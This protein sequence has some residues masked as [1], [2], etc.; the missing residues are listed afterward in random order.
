MRIIIFSFIVIAGMLLITY[1]FSPAEHFAGTLTKPISHVGFDT[2]LRKHVSIDGKVNYKGFKKDSVAF[3]KYLSL[4][5]KNPPNDST[6]NNNEKLAYWINAYNAFTIKLI[7]KNYP[8]KSIK[9]ITT[10]W[11]EK[12]F[13]VGKNK[14]TLNNIENDILR[15]KFAEPRIHFAIVCASYSCPKL[16]NTAFAS[17]NIEKQLETAAID[18][19]NDP[20]RNIITADKVQLSEIFSWFTAD[21]T[22][23]GTI[24][25]FLNKYSKVKIN[26]KAKV[27]YLTYNWNL[28][29]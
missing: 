19:I 16:L 15:K 10:P 3:E 8:I 14:M 12:F 27:N 5:S 24:I 21:F 25:A 4:L 28:N 26:D 13:M 18:F 17:V 29:E 6:W 1:S 9:N 22:K 11:D 2:L 20:K 7:L 23:D